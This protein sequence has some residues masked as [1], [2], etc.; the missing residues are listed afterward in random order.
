MFLI[1]RLAGVETARKPFG[2]G[3]KLSEQILNL[4]KEYKA[5]IEKAGVEPEFYL[6]NV[7]SV[8]NGFKSPKPESTSKSFEVNENKKG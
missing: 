7:P 5:D 1:M 6:E 4:K 2:S 8:I 3:D